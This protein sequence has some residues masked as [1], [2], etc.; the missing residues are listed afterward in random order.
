MGGGHTSKESSGASVVNFIREN[1]VFHF[2]IPYKIVTDNG[3]PFVNKEISATLSGYGIKRK[4]F[5]PYYPQ[6][7]GQAKATNKTIL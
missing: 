6:G 1:I 4:C 5:T 3:T 2:G 7:N